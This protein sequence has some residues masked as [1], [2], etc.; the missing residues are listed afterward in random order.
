[1]TSL[2]SLK[3]CTITKFSKRAEFFSEANAR[4][5][6]NTNGNYHLKRVVFSLKNK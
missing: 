4:N 3:C 5:E 1:M 2:E 6:P